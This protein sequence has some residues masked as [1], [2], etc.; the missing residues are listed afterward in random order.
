MASEAV[1]VRTLQ[2]IANMFNKGSWWVNDS[3][4]MWILQ[5]QDV[6]DDELIQGTTDCLRKAKKLPTIANL[7]EIIQ[8]HPN[9]RIGVPT[10]RE[11]CAACAGSG[12]RELARWYRKE[13]GQ[14]LASYFGLAACDC[15]KGQRLAMGS[16]QPWRHVLA[17]WEDDRM[18]ARD[19]HGRPIVF[20]GTREQPH[21]SDAQKL[22]P[23]ALAERTERHAAT[24]AATKS[25][26]SWHHVG[27]A[28]KPD[29]TK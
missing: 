13:K 11:S 16:V 15:A 7:R 1:V 28:T 8:A 18:T 2:A 14:R 19:E 23:D 24:A 25:T 4:K 5:L 26:G 3:T 6:D 27:T 29:P 22:T 21:L 17:A 12:W 20:C 10:V 9:S